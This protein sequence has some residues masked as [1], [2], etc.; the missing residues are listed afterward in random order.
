MAVQQDRE[1]FL[2]AN[3]ELLIQEL[4]PAAQAIAQELTEHAEGLVQ[5]HQRWHALAQSVAQYLA[6]ASIVPVG[7]THIDH[8]LATAVREARQA[9]QHEVVSPM[10][11]YIH[12]DVQLENNQRAAA[13]KQGT[14]V[15]LR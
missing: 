6:A 15:K 12:R 3:S 5:A 2:A 8:G 10:P 13:A 1:R 14:T 11:H 4:G 7:N 9:L